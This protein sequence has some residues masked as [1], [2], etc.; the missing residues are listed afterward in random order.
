MNIHLAKILVKENIVSLDQ[1]RAAFEE[2]RETGK[3]LGEVL[4]G[5]GYIDESQLVDFLS[6]EYGVPSVNLDEFEIEAVVLKLVP[7]KTVLEH[8][9]IPIG[10]SGSTLVV[11]MSD[12]SN[13]I[14][15]DD[16]RF[17]TGFII[18]PVVAPERA[19]KTAIGKYYGMDEVE[20]KV[21]VD[22]DE[23]PVI[24]DIIKELKDFKN[25]VQKDYGAS[26]SQDEEF[27]RGWEGVESEA[28]QDEEV[29]RPSSFFSQGHEFDQEGYVVSESLG[30]K[31]V[32]NPFVAPSSS[33]NYEVAGGD[34]DVSFEK[35]QDDDLDPGGPLS[36]EYEPQQQPE[37][38][39]L[40][41][42]RVEETL[43]PF[44]TE[45]LPQM[46]ESDPQ[47]DVVSESVEDK[48]FVN[49]FVAPS[50]SQNYEV[51]GGDEDVSF[52]KGQ[53][54][55]L[56]PGG[57]LSKEYEPQ[58]QP[59]EMSLEAHQE[60]EV[61]KQTS[62]FSQGFESPQ[63]LEDLNDDVALELV[64][65]EEASEQFVTSSPQQD[66]FTKQ[67]G[68][69]S[70][71]MAEENEGLKPSSLFSE[72]NVS[73]ASFSPEPMEKEEK[74]QDTPAVI[75][76]H[77]EKNSPAPPELEE[78]KKQTF[79]QTILV[80]DDS[81]TIQKIV[82]ITLERKGYRVVTAADAMQALAKLNEVVPNL[83]FL[84]INLPHLDGYQVCKII[85]ANALTKDIPVVMLSGKDGFFDKAR[86]R[87]AG[88]TDYITKPFGPSALIQAVEKYGG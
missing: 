36:K 46:H 7:R 57:L 17:A 68:E 33:Q 23:E 47:A 32:V 59:E 30:D 37:E 66:E 67:K 49:P 76:L 85:K 15:V 71:E 41:E 43:E 69:I 53:D 80:V 18:K 84:D 65:E 82:A 13:I 3:G 63:Q 24:E 34:E 20:E 75:L 5:L 8:G 88:A 6:K 55:D 28:N 64:Q 48:V 45:S 19:I 10:R 39:S 16:L 14:A 1:V 25:S 77:R 56:D 27:E 60:E 40:E 52:E 58:Q 74:Q 12:P 42:N 62:L 21:K 61:L 29:L 35:G 73:K 22:R 2:Q 86:G 70:P 72:T 79:K 4:V 50:S 9:L 83:I 81:P 54:D 38:E 11:A 44:V 26:S 31:V 51:A 87:I 78:E